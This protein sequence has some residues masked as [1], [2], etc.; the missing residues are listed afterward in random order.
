VPALAVRV[1]ADDGP[2]MRRAGYADPLV[3][4]TMLCGP[5]TQYDPYA[6]DNRRTMTTAHRFIEEQWHALTDGQVIDVRVIVGEAVAPAA[7]C[8]A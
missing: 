5:K 7:S 3:L 6:W 1:S 4:L 2:I 8:C